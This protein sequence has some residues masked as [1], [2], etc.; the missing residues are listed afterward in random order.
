MAETLETEPKPAEET[1]PPRPKDV[2][3]LALAGGCTIRFDARRPGVVMPNGLG[4]PSPTAS[5]TI[6]NPQTCAQDDAGVVV[7]V[8]NPGLKPEALQLS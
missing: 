7:T 8:T 2:L 3:A 6:R 1:K 4:V 5:V